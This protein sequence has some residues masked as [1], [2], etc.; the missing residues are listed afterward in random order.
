MMVLIA[1]SRQNL[2][3][4]SLLKGC[5]SSKLSNVFQLDIVNFI[6]LRSQTQFSIP[7]DAFLPQFILF[8]LLTIEIAKVF[9]Y[10]TSVQF[11]DWYCPY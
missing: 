1:R 8:N 3:K 7:F 10:F 11:S 2:A 5:M 6:L 9:F 4:S